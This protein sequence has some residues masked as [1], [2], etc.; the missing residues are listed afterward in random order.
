MYAAAMLLALSI[1]S[2]GDSCQCCSQQPA[3]SRELA[4][5]RR[6]NAALKKLARDRNKKII[7]L[8]DEIRELCRDARTKTRPLP[9]GEYLRRLQTPAD[10]EEGDTIIPAGD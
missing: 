9:P 5:L 2:A 3:V 4:E 1:A 7:K 8:E 10:I 6:E